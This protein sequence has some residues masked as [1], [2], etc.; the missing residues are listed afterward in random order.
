M[1][2]I[3]LTKRNVE[4]LPAPDPSGKQALYWAEGEDYRGLGILVSG[5]AATKSWVCQAKLKTGQTRRITLGPCNVLTIEQAWE[6]AKAKLAEIYRGGDPKVSAARRKRAA[7]TLAEVL[8]DYL[9]RLV[10]PGA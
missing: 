9:G 6:D 4:R 10:E 3:K 8:E 7:M 2:K 5:V 1:A